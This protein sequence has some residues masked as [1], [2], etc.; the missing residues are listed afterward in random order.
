MTKGQ[1]HA[2]TLAPATNWRPGATAIRAVAFTTLVSA[3]VVT[4]ANTKSSV[5]VLLTPIWAPDI[6]REE[7]APTQRLRDQPIHARHGYFSLACTRSRSYLF[8]GR[9]RPETMK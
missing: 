4:L 8:S 7:S 9:E 1:V 3:A 6:S 5:P 2:G